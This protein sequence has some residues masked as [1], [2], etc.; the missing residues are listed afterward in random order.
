MTEFISKEK[1]FANATKLAE[2]LLESENYSDF[3]ERLSTSDIDYIENKTYEVA[4][5]GF[6]DFNHHLY[7]DINHMNS[8][9]GGLYLDMTLVLFIMSIIICS[10][11]EYF[12]SYYMEKLFK[13]R[14]WDYSNRK[15]NINGRVCLFNMICFGILSLVIM[16]GVNPFLLDT[17]HKIDPMVLKTVVSILMTI[18][19]IDLGI[20]TK[21]IYNFKGIS[22]NVLTDATE[23]VNKK[24]KEVLLSKGVLLRRIAQ[25]Y[26]NFKIRR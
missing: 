22:K 9:S 18:F 3:H 10:L 21:I 15:F 8:I 2:I 20:S 12:T 24:V 1:I 17:I 5:S 7:E 23:E 25:S 11:L 14:W 4:P 26:P 16:Y 6:I 19:L 13:T